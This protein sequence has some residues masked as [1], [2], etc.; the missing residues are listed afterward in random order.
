MIVSEELKISFCPV[1]NSS[2]SEEI[3]HFI[4]SWNLLVSFMATGTWL[5]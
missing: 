3:E 4:L 1:Y 2:D 5:K